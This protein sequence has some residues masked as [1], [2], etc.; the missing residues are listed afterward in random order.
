MIMIFFIAWLFSGFVCYLLAERKGMKK[1]CAFLA[2]ILFGI[3]A[4]AY[5]LIKKE[6]VKT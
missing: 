1:G 2:G 5:Y 4:V 3:F 6:N